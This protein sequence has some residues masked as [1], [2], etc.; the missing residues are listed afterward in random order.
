MN[1]TKRQKSRLDSLIKIARQSKTKRQVRR[2]YHVAAI[3]KG[4][5][6]ISLACNTTKTH[7][8]KNN[9]YPEIINTVHAEL[10]AIL[11]AGDIDFSD[12]VIF[13][14]RIDNN[15]NIANSAPCEHCQKL[16]RSLK[17][18]RVIHT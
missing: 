1:L 12:C 7:P 6:R 3:Y 9:Y 8:R 10:A 16:I 18:K 17:F 15:G 13:V 5:A 11:A 14:I 4:K 2:Q